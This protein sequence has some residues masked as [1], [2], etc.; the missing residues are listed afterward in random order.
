MRVYC[1]SALETEEAALGHLEVLGF[2]SSGG[3]VA[4]SWSLDDDS[5]EEPAPYHKQIGC[6]VSVTRRPGFTRIPIGAQ[7]G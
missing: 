2:P 3:V 1:Q 5:C 7:H 6:A 4:C